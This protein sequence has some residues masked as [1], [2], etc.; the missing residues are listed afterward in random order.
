MGGWNGSE[1]GI[2]RGCGGAIGSGA[3]RIGFTMA[4]PGGRLL[5]RIVHDDFDCLRRAAAVHDGEGEAAGRVCH[6]CDLAI[7][8]GT[9]W[10]V[11]HNGRREVAVH[12]DPDCLRQALGVEFDS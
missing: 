5:R 8:P 12:D 4:A 9:A 3:E 7:E 2:C 10:L 1:A 11:Y 6:G